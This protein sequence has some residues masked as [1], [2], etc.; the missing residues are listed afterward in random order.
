MKIIIVGGTPTAL[1]LANLLGDEHQITIIEEDEEKA[2]KFAN[3]TSAL[4]VK[5]DGTDISILNE[6]GLTDAD[7]IVSTSDDKTNLMICEIAKSEEVPKVIALVNEPKNEELFQKLGITQLVSAVGTN[8]TGIKNLLSQVGDARIVCQLGTGELQVIEATV[9]KGNPLV[10]QPPIINGAVIAAIYR[11]GEIM[12]PKSDTMIQEGD[13][14]V[15]VV[16]TK[17]VQKIQD[18]IQGK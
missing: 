15:I 3:S 2:K 10:E 18:F 14:L 4:V 9:S 13:V 1:T 8:V 17:N 7:A 12:I 6:A 16:E 5:G 11:S